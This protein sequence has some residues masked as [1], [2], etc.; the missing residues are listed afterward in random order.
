M[1]HLT[2]S[3]YIISKERQILDTLAE[4]VKPSPKMF[5]EG[6]HIYPK[7]QPLSMWPYE[8]YEYLSAPVSDPKF[9]NKETK[10]V[11]AINLP[12][13]A[14][15]ILYKRVTKYDVLRLKYLNVIAIQKWIG[16]QLNE[17]R[18]QE[19]FT[20]SRN[21]DLRWVQAGG[22]EMKRFKLY[23]LLNL[24]TG[25]DITKEADAKKIPYLNILRFADYKN[26]QAIIE[27][28][29]HNNLNKKK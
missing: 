12:L 18:K 25:G 24:A 10:G 11:P 29:M 3:D 21:R 23:N 8:E 14:F 26:T 20:F 15:P 4:Y 7:Y 5:H 2:Y 1:K 22:D 6:K 28:N 19:D 27:K 13:I 16:E 17:L 9:L